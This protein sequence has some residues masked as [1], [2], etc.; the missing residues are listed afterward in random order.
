MK[1]TNVVIFFL[2]LRI[3]SFILLFLLF[4][5]LSLVFCFHLSSAPWFS[6]F[7]YFVFLFLLLLLQLLSSFFSF[8]LVPPLC[9]ILRFTYLCFSSVVHFASLPLLPFQTP[10]SISI[11]F[12][13]SSALSL[14]PSQLPFLPSSNFHLYLCASY[15]LL[16][17]LSISFSP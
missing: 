3:L 17:S 6:L 1:L 13:P 12:S 15:A 8:P 14:L 9:F 7:S 10:S 5:F 2:I 16:S 4:S 11:S